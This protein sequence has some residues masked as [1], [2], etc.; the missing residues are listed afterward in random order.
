MV[1]HQKYF[2][3]LQ[4]DTIV[5]NVLS[6]IRLAKFHASRI[7]ITETGRIVYIFYSLVD[8]NGGIAGKLESGYH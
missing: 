7:I 2:L 8:L 5:V 6:I 4:I 3:F 1:L